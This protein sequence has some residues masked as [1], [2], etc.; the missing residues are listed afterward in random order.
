[1]KNP[2]TRIQLLET[3]LQPKLLTPENQLKALALS[4]RLPRK[5]MEILLKQVGNSLS[6]HP[7]LPQLETTAI[8]LIEKHCIREGTAT[9][10]PGGTLSHYNFAYSIFSYLLLYLPGDSVNK[11]LWA[12]LQS[13]NRNLAGLASTTLFERIQSN[14]PKLGSY[15]LATINSPFLVKS[16]DLGG[17]IPFASKNQKLRELICEKLTRNLILDVN[18]QSLQ[19]FL[20]S[21]P[22]K[23]R[24]TLLV[25]ILKQ[26]RRDL[27]PDILELLLHSLGE[28]QSD[29]FL[30]VLQLYLNYPTPE[31]K[32]TALKAINRMFSPKAVPI[33]LE[34][35]R[36][37]DLR[38]T[39]RS[40]LNLL[41]DYL[42]E[43]AKWEKLIPPSGG[44]K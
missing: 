8:E 13:S 19:D 41:E 30:P 40:G 23:E 16:F 33:L 26:E 42:K 15:Y 36:D 1:M 44:T 9:N 35:L 22:S 11:K 25:N 14:K 37:P 18:D 6:T 4:P 27:D 10:T 38:K 24:E 31:I 5:Y 32:Y 3:I 12:W 28:F 39:A 2:F 20:T 29:R 34:A 17:A 21:L 43:K 7:P